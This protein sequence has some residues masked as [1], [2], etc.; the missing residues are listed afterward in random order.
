MPYPQY[1][2]PAPY[3]QPLP[4]PGT[5][6]GG[7]C[8]VCGGGPAVDATFRGH[9]GM[10]ILMRFLRTPGPFCRSCG[11]AVVRD[12]SAKTLLLGWWGIISF[13]ATPVTLIINVIQ[14]RKIK[15]L[16]PLQSYGHRP[17]LDPGKPL[18]RRPAMLGLL[19]PILVIVV[20]IVAAVA[21]QSDPSN[22]AVGD[23]IQHTGTDSAKIV[24]CSSPAA[25]YTV[26]MRLSGNS[27]SGCA[28][29][30]TVI[31]SYTEMDKSGDFVLC[32]GPGP[33]HS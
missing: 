4:G 5:I 19:V 31:A 16:P 11:T 15:M 32:L 12:M 28:T 33:T 8:R 6:T 20:L 25:Q 18:V 10:I 30:P 2:V 17:P 3:G 21:G 7:T 26:L 23:C 22:A 14:W 24:S 13:F 27:D 9:R 29:N 1:S